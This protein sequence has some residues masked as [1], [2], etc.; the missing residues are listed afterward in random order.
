MPYRRF[1][2]DELQP[3]PSDQPT[4]AAPFGPPPMN[5]PPPQVAPAEPEYVEQA[6]ERKPHKP[7]K[8]A[9]HAKPAKHHR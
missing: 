2:G 6:P 5:L 7:K 8:H 1:P 4:I 9:K 3:S